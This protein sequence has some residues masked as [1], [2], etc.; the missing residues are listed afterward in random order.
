MDQWFVRT[1]RT[2]LRQILTARRFFGMKE[3]RHT[4]PLAIVGGLQVPGREV[5]P[6]EVPE[7]K[8]TVVCTVDLLFS[9]LDGTSYKI[10]G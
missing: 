8:E 5:R 4:W 3:R 6:L 10:S 1:A 7:G 9:S 2:D